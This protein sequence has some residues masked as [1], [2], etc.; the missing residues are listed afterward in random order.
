MS[1]SYTTTPIQP[2]ND[3]SLSAILAASTHM[4]QHPQSMDGRQQ[5]YQQS[6]LSSPYQNYSNSPSEG[7]SADPA[8]AAQYQQDVKFQPD[9]RS[10]PSSHNTP[11]SDHA[12]A[13]QSQRAGTFPEYI[14][15]QRSYQDGAPQQ[16]RY[17]QQQPPTQHAQQHAA[18]A[19]SSPSI[20]MS[21]GHQHG[22]ASHN[23]S[24]DL[25]MP[26]DPNIAASSPTYPPH[27][28]YSPYP[29]QDHMQPYAGQ[30]GQPMY[31]RPEWAGHGHYAQPMYGHAPGSGA[32]GAPGMVAQVARPPVVWVRVCTDL[33]R[34]HR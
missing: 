26:I 15:Q 34:V 17:Q 29:P 24:S 8:S 33:A 4:N 1:P 25:D 5:E 23:T 11:T 22:N 16:Q 2:S 32:P 21:N 27:Q 7:V 13:P 3:T 19:Q 18:M 6:G 12:F 20:P 14:Q 9:V 31:A 28:Q 30:P 10:H